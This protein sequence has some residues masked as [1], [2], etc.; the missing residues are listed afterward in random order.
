MD[1][2]LTRRRAIQI[3][4]TATGGLALG[5]AFSG[6]ESDAARGKEGGKIGLYVRI[7]PDSR[8]TIGAPSAEMGQGINTALPMM[9]AEELDVD[10][11]QVAIEQ[12][13]LMIKKSD[14]G[15][16]YTWVHFPQGA[17]GSNSI[18]SGW[19]LLRE[20]GARARRL[21]VMAAAARWKVP[22]GECITSAGVISHTK[23]KR[24]L[25]YGDVAAEAATLTDPAEAPKLKSRNDYR[26]LGKP[27]R[28]AQSLAIVTG[29][30]EFG[31]DAE[32]PGMLHAV[33]AR[34]P[35]FD[36]Q[37][38]AVDDAAA[39]AVKGVK[40]VVR[41]D[42]PKA[43]EPYT[44][45]IAAGV[46]VVADTLWAA[47]KGREALKVT[48]STSPWANETTEGSR[49]EA[50]RMMRGRGQIV[51]NEGDFDGAI[52]K[53]AR[54]VEHVYEVP[55]VSHATL[56]PQNCIAHVHAN[57]I[58]IVAPTQTPGRASRVANAIT[59]VDRGKIAVKMTRLGGGFG[60][61]LEVDY[62]AEAVLI[63]REVKAPVR[64]FWTRED[65]LAHDFYRPDGRHHMILG[66][67]EAG[68]VIAWKHRL[69]SAGKNNRREGVKPEEIWQADFYEMDFPGKLVPNFQREYFLLPS[70]AP[71]RSWRA[72]GH[73]ANAFAIHSFLDEA[74]R[75]LGKDP[76]AFQLEILGTEDRDIPW[77]SDGAVF[78]PARLA[79][80]LKLAAE[81]AGW[82]A[83]V[84]AGRGRGIA[85]HFTFSSYCAHVVEVS[86]VNGKLTVERVVT[87]I[88]CGFAVNPLGVR[89]Q[90]EG[91]INDALSVALAQEITVK[92][93]A[94]VERNFDTYR[95]MRI[96]GSP[97]AIDVHIVDSPRDP[98]GVGEPPVPPFA[99]ALCNAIFAATGKR[100]RRLPIGDQLSL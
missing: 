71:R 53:A 28:N 41:L 76:L 49:A 26:I 27:T 95:M 87:A 31:V 2:M 3:G 92:N 19:P 56:E 8:V 9:V 11:A 16:S 58:D 93:G 54:V 55:Y 45:V 100:I 22:A 17:G 10:W 21:L 50:V 57:G 75:E 72:P 97:K 18:I 73:T 5:I 89:A 13:P 59:G 88:D 70:G 23:S 63:S 81:R 80:V 51:N 6:G 7:E 39:R 82:G 38:Q 90:V 86:V 91:G 35:A 20:A 1:T 62:V 99:P 77:E 36:V 64:V 69:A 25:R 98:T 74:A 83:P 37:I 46:A 60:R 67:D 79:G 29:R 14:D 4:A 33:I 40:H 85:G 12:M 94:V 52:K 32:M 44:T 61:R 68:K 42:G 24:T 66:V 96:D 30:E 47:M 43:D 65:D 78:N 34:A 48:W 15:Q 84:P